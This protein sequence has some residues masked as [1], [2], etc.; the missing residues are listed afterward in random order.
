MI[1]SDQA[2]IGG[3]PL[4]GLLTALQSAKGNVLLQQAAILQFCATA[5]S[6]GINLEIEVEQQL[7]GL[8]IQKVQAFVVSKSSGPTVAV[9]A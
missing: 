6:V 2:T 8:L 1:E 3:Q 9:Q 4:I 5:P 7:L